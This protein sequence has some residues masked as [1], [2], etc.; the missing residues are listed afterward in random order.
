MNRNYIFLTILMLF[1]AVGTIFLNKTEKLKQIEPDKLLWEIIQ[2]T[3]YVSTDQVAKMIIQQDPSLEIIDV[4]NEKEFNNFSLPKAINIP[5]DSLLSE[6]SLENFG[7]PGTK[8]VFISNDDIKADQA[9]I[10]AKRLG[11]DG[12]YVMRGGLNCWMRTIIQPIEPPEHAPLTEFAT[13]EF[14]KG[15]KLY[16]TGA[17]PGNTETKKVKVIVKRRKKTKAASGGC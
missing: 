10:I 16:F 11:F 1:L 3:R 7:I 5:V 15:A 4:R 13:Y 9:W 12:M 6:T 14:R 8:V 17:K 2:P